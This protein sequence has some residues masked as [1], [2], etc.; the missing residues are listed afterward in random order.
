MVIAP[1]T[2]QI[3]DLSKVAYLKGKSSEQISAAAEVEQ[4]SHAAMVTVVTGFIDGL[5]N[6]EVGK[7]ETA[8]S[9]SSDSKAQGNLDQYNADTTVASFKSDVAGDLAK[10]IYAVKQFLIEGDLAEQKDGQELKFKTKDSLD[11]GKIADE[12]AQ[13]LAQQALKSVQEKLSA[14][15]ISIN[16]GEAAQLQQEIIRELKKPPEPKNETTTAAEIPT[17]KPVDHEKILAAITNFTKE[18]SN[19][20]AVKTLLK[21][22]NG[23]K[24]LSALNAD[25]SNSIPKTDT[26]ARNNALSS[27][28]TNYEQNKTF[29]NNNI[30]NSETFTTKFNSLDDENKLQIQIML[31]NL[32]LSTKHTNTVKEIAGSAQEI[33]QALSGDSFQQLSN[34]L[35]KLKE[36]STNENKGNNLDTVNNLLKDFNKS[37]QDIETNNQLN[38]IER[39]NK[40]NEAIEAFTKKLS[41]ELKQNK[42]S[43]LDIELIE[44]R[45]DPSKNETAEQSQKAIT[46]RVL[47]NLNISEEQLKSFGSLAIAAVVGLMV[48][49]PNAI[50]NLVKGGT[51]LAA[52]AAQTLPMFF[53]AQ[54]MMQMSQ[55]GNG[56]TA[57]TQVA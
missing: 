53:Q 24:T 33:K 41:T 46:E 6:L 57:S 19:L 3:F 30:S 31:K 44:E 42:L 25:L 21:K 7:L 15:G 18:I 11:G 9:N 51:G 55:N 54:A 38:K 26:E 35:N 43:T 40:K 12:S 23:L 39:I 5:I 20:D 49:C 48:F 10:N 14:Y 32:E 16:A 17:E 29:I 8:A 22:D 13:E 2:A 27:F 45:L 52:M 47:K 36:N 56:T 4:P 50:G 34:K 37:L 28:E 1:T